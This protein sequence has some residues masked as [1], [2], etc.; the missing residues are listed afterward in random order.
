LGTRKRPIV[1]FSHH[2]HRAL[3]QR[4]QEGAPVVLREHA[5]VEADDDAFVLLGA[6]EAADAL[7]EFEDG[8]GE[9]VVAE[10]VAAKGLP[11]PLRWLLC[12]HER[13]CR[14]ARSFFE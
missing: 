8:F 10:G 4:S 6:D 14:T 11:L 12:V 3:R 9:R 7:A 1:T 13:D 2:L 5:R